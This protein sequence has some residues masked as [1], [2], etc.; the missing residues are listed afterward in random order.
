MRRRLS[1]ILAALAALGL[2]TSAY[3]VLGPTKASQLVTVT[4]SGSCPIPGH[5][6][7]NSAAFTNL[8]HADGTSSPF[9]IPAKQVFIITDATLTVSG[10]GANDAMLA[11]LSIGTASG[12]TQIAGQYDTAGPTGAVKSTFTFPAGVAVKSTSI[13]CAR[14][15][16]TTQGGSVFFSGTAHGYFAPDK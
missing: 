9:A 13:L 16:D 3:A 1:T 7:S 2:A 8:I 12:G 10:Q 4:S 11:L 6:S 15:I 14:L 5:P